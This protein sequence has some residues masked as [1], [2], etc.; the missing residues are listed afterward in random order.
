MIAFVYRCGKQAPGDGA[1]AAS[2]CCVVVADGRR[3]RIL[4]SQPENGGRTSL[5]EHAELLNHVDALEAP[6]TNTGCDTR[7]QAG[8][9]YPQV[10]RRGAHCLE[11]HRRFAA[12]VA[13]EI[14]NIV[15]DW[16]S[17][18]IVLT[19]APGM[20]GFAAR[21]RAGRGARGH[22]AESAGEGL[23]SAQR[24][25]AFAASRAGLKARSVSPPEHCT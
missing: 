8:P 6:F 22:C 21:A 17:G 14:A 16:H 23:R 12:E 24:N 7:R 20:L 10:E 13:A 25:R 18:S 2:K 19:A 4:L 5:I 3:A 11:I 9:V 1:M 15:S